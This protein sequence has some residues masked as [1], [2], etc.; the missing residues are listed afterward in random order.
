VS[1]GLGALR[2][3]GQHLA[4]DDDTLNWLQD[5]PQRLHEGDPEAL[6][7]VLWAGLGG[8]RSGFTPL[9]LLI[10]LDD[11]EPEELTALPGAVLGALME[12]MP[13]KGK[14]AGG[15]GKPWDWNVAAAVWST[16]WGQPESAFDTTTL[17]RFHDLSDGRSILYAS[18]SE[19]GAQSSGETRI[20]TMAEFEELFAMRG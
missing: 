19:G 8:E 11:C 1:F 14:G 17:R 13:R 18:A 12:T 6:V 15:S 7:Y 4:P 3:I 2:A 9:E 20:T 5:L 10:V 16:E